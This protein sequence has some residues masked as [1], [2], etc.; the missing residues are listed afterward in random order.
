VAWQELEGFHVEARQHPTAAG[1]PAG[2]LCVISTR[3]TL[4]LSVCHASRHAT[5]V[6]VAEWL[7]RLTA[8]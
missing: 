1:K 4:C 3:T 7:A 5:Q 6:S 8:V 2:A